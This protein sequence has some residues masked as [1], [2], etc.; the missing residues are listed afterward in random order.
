[1][2]DVTREQALQLQSLRFCIA[3][4][5]QNDSMGWW[6]DDSLTTTGAYLLERIFPG[7]PAITGRKLALTAANLRH[8]AALAHLDN[9]NHL[10]QLAA[11]NQAKLVLRDLVDTQS[12]VDLPPIDSIGSLH[13]MLVKIIST[14]PEYEVVNRFPEQRVM[15]IRLENH[16]SSMLEQAT[17]LA[18]AYLEGDVRDP[19]FPY[20]VE[21]G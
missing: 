2:S 20:I 21:R 3:R 5:G 7:A 17:A 4:A 1:M 12:W 9:V 8:E 14:Q 13:D 18:W 15:Q 10:F 16:K 6:E 11:E 19:I